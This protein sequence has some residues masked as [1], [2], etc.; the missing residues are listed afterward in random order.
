M[1]IVKFF[2]GL[3]K[4]KDELLLKYV[5]QKNLFKCIIDIFLE[6]ATKANLIYSSILEL[7]DSLTKDTFN[8]K[9]SQ[10]LVSY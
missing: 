9:F 5:M 6:N 3:I 2:K 4:G 7:F 10:Y 1:W 8:K